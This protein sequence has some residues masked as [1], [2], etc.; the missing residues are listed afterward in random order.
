MTF[1]AGFISGAAVTVSL[2][3]LCFGVLVAM[4]RTYRGST[5]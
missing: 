1:L 2:E 5:P 3:L 4:A